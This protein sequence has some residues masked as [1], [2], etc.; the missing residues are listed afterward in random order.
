MGVLNVTPDSFSDGRQYQNVA[1]AIRHAEKLVAEG[2]DLVD[3]GGES[4]RPG[5]RGTD[6]AEEIQRVVPVI[7]ELATILPVPISIDTS[8]PEVMIAAVEAGAGLINDVCALQTEGAIEVA[9]ALCVPVCLMHMQGK[10]ETMQDDPCYQDVVSEVR[11]FLQQRVAACTEGGIPEQH[12]L[13]D[14]GFGF[15][16]K[17]DHNR[18]LLLELGAFAGLG[19]P[20]TVGFS[21]KG[22]VGALLGNLEQDRAVGSAGLALLAVQR[23]ARVVRAHDVV[24]TRDL[25]RSWE[26]LQ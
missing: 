5:S 7:Q 17:F 16:K 24:P 13:I 3:V 18:R 12:L 6:A 1:D 21:R 2:A 11:D 4:T 23:G 19:V 8:K 22:F 9:R 15:G 25:I 14:P 20:L 10:P 26:S